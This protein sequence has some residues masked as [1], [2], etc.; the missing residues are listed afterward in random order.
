MRILI[1]YDGS[2]HSDTALDDLKRAGLPR[3]S[4]VLVVS[5]GDL[6]MSNPPL[7]EVAAEILTSR[8]GSRRRSDRRKRT[9]TG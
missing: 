5:V 3:D 2:E 7:S 6:L 4:K 1:G 9:P 8:R